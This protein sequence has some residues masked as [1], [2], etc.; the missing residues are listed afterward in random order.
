MGL[1]TTTITVTNQIDEELPK[2]GFIPR[3]QIRSI[4]IENV[5]VDTGCTHLCLPAN[6]ILELGLP[7]QEEIEVKTVIEVKKT[8]LFKL[9]IL[10]VEGRR[11][12]FE[13]IELPGGEDPLLGVIPL[14]QLKLQP[15]LIN[16]RLVLLPKPEKDS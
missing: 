4:T 2:R 13:C 15:D 10:T 12:K 1:V 8:R 3:E 16:E 11:D 6:T 7:F 5:L 14:E 9:A